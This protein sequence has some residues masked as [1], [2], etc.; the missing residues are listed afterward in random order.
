MTKE[1]MQTIYN[2]NNFETIKFCN[3]KNSTRPKLE[4]VHFT[5]TETTGTDGYMLLKVTTPKLADNDYPIMNDIKIY[6]GEIDFLL[7]AENLKT[8]KFYKNK[9]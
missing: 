4:C 3:G 8:V 2:K 1:N 7:K 6:K 9:K 5:N